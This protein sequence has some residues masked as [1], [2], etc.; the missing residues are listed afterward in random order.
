MSEQIENLIW[1]WGSRIVLAL[2]PFII[3][4]GGKRIV[5]R[6]RGRKIEAEAQHTTASTGISMMQLSEITATKYMELFN[7]AEDELRKS[8]QHWMN[9]DF[10]IR[11]ML[12]CMK[13][14]KIDGW[15]DFEQR[16]KTMF[17]L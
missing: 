10:L 13:V 9:A 4:F 11:E 16:A 15:E 3:W 12:Y 1:E 8:R 5:D 2:A 6:A 7:Q 17:Q 14:A